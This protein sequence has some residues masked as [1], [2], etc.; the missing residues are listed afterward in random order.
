MLLH[1]PCF[2]T[3]L[4]QN[5]PFM[6]NKLQHL[7]SILALCLGYS[8]AQ[9]QYNY[10]FQPDNVQV[11][12]P[13][14]L[15]Y[16][17]PSIAQN[18]TTLASTANFM[19]AAGTDEN[20]MLMGHS[21][22]NL[23]VNTLLEHTS[24]QTARQKANA[25][26]YAY[27]NTDLQVGGL[28]TYNISQGNVDMSISKFDASGN[29]KYA[30]WIGTA[31]NY[32]ECMMVVPA[33][34]G[35]YGAG[36]YLV[37]GVTDEPGT[38]CPY[39]AKISDLSSLTNFIVEWKKVFKSG[40]SIDEIPTS[41]F[42]ESNGTWIVAGHTEGGTANSLFTFAF[43][44][45]GATVGNWVNYEVNSGL[46]ETNAFI[47]RSYSGAG[48][49]VMS[50]TVGDGSGSAIGV[51]E[52]SNNRSSVYWNNTYY[53]PYSDQNHS[54]AI[55]W[56][57]SQYVV[58][59][60][61]L[62]SAYNTGYPG[63]LRLSISGSVDNFYHYATADGEFARTQFMLPIGTSDYALKV[64]YDN[65][66]G[67]GLIRTNAAG[68][69]TGTCP[70][71]RDIDLTPLPVQTEV[72]QFTANDLGY[73][74]WYVESLSNVDGDQYDCDGTYLTSY[75]PYA[76]DKPQDIHDMMDVHA[77]ALAGTVT[78]METAETSGLKVFP[79]PSNGTFQ[80]QFGEQI[81]AFYELTNLNGQRIATGIPTSTN[82]S[83]SLENVPKGIYLLRV[84]FAD[85]Q[86]TQKVSIQ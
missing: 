38:L 49:Y 19:S 73:L 63:F 14:F 46:D 44:N 5:T 35:V 56:T 62:Q 48:G 72:K 10:R 3:L 75:K 4:H 64:L 53:E 77:P 33:G 81:P 59:T 54:V 18:G 65:Q 1:T 9:A 21:A 50:Y 37:I 74:M 71:N 78:G 57:G 79:N 83:L 16:N 42:Q 47:Q 67:Y 41:V 12:S 15:P 30:R 31:E 24:T 68:N 13:L 2:H 22:T 45:T 23:N 7:L 27:N 51:M 52:I 26:T 60:G 86:W 84:Q 70:N 25:V 69:S 6:K 20:Y 76:S 40:Y 39:I 43:D 61:H 85:R 55:Y 36:S 34:P 17:V 11:P 28:R 32:E 8:G 80:I 66:D 82:T 58:G 29:L